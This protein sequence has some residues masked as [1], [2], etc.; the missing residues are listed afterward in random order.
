MKRIE[1][2]GPYLD[3]FEA[4]SP[5]NPVLVVKL[6]LRDDSFNRICTGNFHTTVAQYYGIV[7]DGLL[8]ADHIFKGLK[9]P[10]M[11]GK[12]M[13]ADKSVIVYSWR[14][15]FDYV[16]VGSRFDGKPLGKIPPPNRVF[17]VLVREEPPNDYKVFGS[18]EHWNW[19]EQD[20]TLY[21]A[22]VD[23]ADR[24]GEKIWSREQ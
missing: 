4:R 15:E 2:V 10:L 11:F 9:R 8:Q 5:E 16:W 21:G 14:P 19:V 24:Y 3:I 1:R 17:V 23:W 22:P 18:V 7:Q 13:N 12:D 20:A 6:G